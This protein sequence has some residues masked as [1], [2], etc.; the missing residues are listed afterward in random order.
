MVY[1]TPTSRL[2]HKAVRI[3]S[4]YRNVGVIYLLSFALFIVLL[5]GVLFSVLYI[6]KFDSRQKHS[7]YVPITL[8]NINA[9]PVQTLPAGLTTADATNSSCTYFGCFN[10]YR[11]GSQGNK[12]LVYVYPPKVYLDSMDRPI[13]S[14]MT[15]EFYQ[16][17]NTIINSKFYTPNPYE[18][19]I[20]VPSMDTLNQNKLRLQEVSRALGSLPL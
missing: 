18:A 12:L 7:E 5:Y 13:T 20:F 10:V 4:H 2:P 3:P 15:K 17:L 16:I 6:F 1:I 11:C 9:L 14:K 19:C 8:N